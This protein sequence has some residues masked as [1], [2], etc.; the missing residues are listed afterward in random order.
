M[1]FS[2]FSIL[3]TADFS[4][5]LIEDLIS[6]VEVFGL[7]LHRSIFDRNLPPTL[8]ILNHIA[9]NSDALS[10]DFA[11]FS[12]E[13]KIKTL[14]GINKTVDISLLKDELAIDTIKTI[15]QIKK[16]QA[17]NGEEACQRYII[18][19]CQS[20]LNAI[21][22]FGLFLL[23][24]WQPEDLKIDIVPPFQTIVDLKHAA[25]IMRELYEN[26]VYRKHLARRGDTQ[27]IML[28]FSDGTKDGGYFMANWSIYKAK[29]ELTSISREYGVSV[30]F[31]DGRGGP[32]ARGGG[33]THKF[34]SSMGKN[35]ANDAIQLTIQGQ[36]V[37]SNFGTV[38]S[39]QFNLEQ[40]LNAGVY[41]YLFSAKNETFTKEE[42]R[43]MQKIA[44]ESL[45]EYESVKNHP[46]FLEYLSVISPRRF[47][48]QTNI[49]SRPVKRGSSSKL[50]LKDLRAIPFVGAWSQ[51]KQNVPGFYGVGAAL[52]KLDDAEN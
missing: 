10:H 25:Q 7:I 12:D 46:Q 22:V 16:I 2:I 52:K 32:P 39:A 33:K 45:V 44:D 42:E 9:E 6:K 17:E 35:I 1:K 4:R 5:I 19:Q 38:N 41:S 21:E 13:E 49:G 36:T 50:T 28:G 27:T 24:G 34:F 14:L 47:Y 29:D 3:I 37:S 30:V 26:P 8:N 43:L 20:A 31:F 18:S 40:L 51:L 11:E 23:G 48:S 15:S